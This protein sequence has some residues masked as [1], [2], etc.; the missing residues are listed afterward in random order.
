MS[1]GQTAKPL[2]IWS[3]A[4]AQLT[5]SGGGS[6]GR[7]GQFNRFY[8]A[9]RAGREHYQ[10]RIG[11]GGDPISQAGLAGT[12]D[13]QG[14]FQQIKQRVGCGLGKFR[15]ERGNSAAIVPG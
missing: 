6:Q 13:E 2:F 4:E 14:W 9:G 11:P 7:V 3:V 12:L 8:G 10:G 15:V 1:Q 5:C